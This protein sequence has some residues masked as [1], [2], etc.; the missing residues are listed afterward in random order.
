M[1]KA[2]KAAHYQLPLSHEMKRP[3]DLIPVSGINL[4]DGKPDC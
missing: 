1:G 4:V 3:L 2:K